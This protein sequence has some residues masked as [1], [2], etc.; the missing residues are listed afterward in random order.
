MG[1]GILI[2]FASAV[3]AVRC[4]VEVQ[5]GVVPRNGR[6]APEPTHRASASA[7]M[8]A[9]WWWTTTDLLG[10]AEDVAARLE[11]IAETGGI[12]FSEDVVAAGTGQGCRR[13]SPIWASNP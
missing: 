2:E 7:S 9:T 6:P 8:S 1:D 13:N 3:D 10:D 5:R 4:A 12:C 11:G